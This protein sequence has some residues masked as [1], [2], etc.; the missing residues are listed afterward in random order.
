MVV[1]PYCH[2]EY[3]STCKVCPYCGKERK[4][5]RTQPESVLIDS[6]TKPDYSGIV[7]RYNISSYTSSRGYS[8]VVIEAHI[9]QRYAVIVNTI[10][11]RHGESWHPFPITTRLNEGRN[12]F[13]VSIPQNATELVISFDHGQGCEVKVYLE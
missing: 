4:K 12:E 9:T 2:R 3:P 7:K 6:F 5:E 1:C 10:K 13:S 8:K 11:V